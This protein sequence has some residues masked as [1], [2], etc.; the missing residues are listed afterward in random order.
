MHEEDKYQS[1]M[2][3]AI[4]FSRNGNAGIFVLLKFENK[5][6]SEICYRSGTVNSKSFVGKVSFELSGNSN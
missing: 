2:V 6:G 1:M 4:E 5:L 3:C